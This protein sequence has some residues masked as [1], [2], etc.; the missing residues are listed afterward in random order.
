M[1]W[2]ADLET[3][4]A[5]PPTDE[6]ERF[7]TRIEQIVGAPDVPEGV[8]RLEIAG[9]HDFLDHPDLAVAGYRRALDAG[10]DEHRTRQATIQLASS[11]RNLGEPAGGLQ[12]LAALRT[13][14]GDGLDDAVVVFTALMNVDLG[15]ER[16]AVSQLIHALA[17]HLP[18]YGVSARHY[19]DALHHD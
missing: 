15:H 2:E 4:W 14:A 18:R 3:A 19:A 6:C 11:L 10:L 8:R 16:V 9:A 17:E 7:I 13:D 5:D 12:L 1:G